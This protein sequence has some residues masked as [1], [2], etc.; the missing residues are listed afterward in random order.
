MISQTGFGV[1]NIREVAALPLLC[2]IC[3][4]VA[5]QRFFATPDEGFVDI[6]AGAKT[7]K[8][9]Y[10]RKARKVLSLTAPSVLVKSVGPSDSQ[11]ELVAP[12]LG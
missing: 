12:N 7:W 3:S 5:G 9:K 10:G 6:A 11:M 1:I 8:D 4:K 2:M